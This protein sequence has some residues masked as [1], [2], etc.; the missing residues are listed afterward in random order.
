MR[1][2]RAL[3]HDAVLP[4]FWIAGDV[5]QD[6]FGN[7][8]VMPGHELAVVVETGFDVVRGRRAEFAK[9]DV[10]FAR[11]DR[12]HRQADR[13]RQANRVVHGL[14]VAAPAESATE[15]LLVQRD[16]RAFG[17]Q[18]ARD[19]V[20]EAGRRLGADPQLGRFAV[21]GHRGGRVHRLHLRVVDVAR[22]I[23]AAEHALG[24]SQRRLGVALVLVSHAVAS[25]VAAYC[26]K[27]LE[28]LLA[29]EMRARRVAPGHLQKVLGR[30]RSFDRGADD[31]DAFG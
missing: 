5:G 25:L 15:E 17:L 2:W 14:V 6:G 11:P 31:A 21:G 3:H 4:R 8:T 9:G 29:I 18:H 20:E 7:D 28:R 16:F 24:A 10:V 30:L 19:A 27:I 22:A 13:L 1:D 26:R 23:F 12:L